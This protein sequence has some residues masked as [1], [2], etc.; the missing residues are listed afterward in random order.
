M[1]NVNPVECYAIVEA[2]RN[3][4]CQMRA[5]EI[6]SD[7]LSRMHA[8]LEAFKLHPSKTALVVDAL[9]KNGRVSDMLAFE[10]LIQKSAETIADHE[11]W[12]K[13]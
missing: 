4:F 11:W 5:G 9:C 12:S 7:P 13:Q 2:A 1:M 8:L 3:Q 6:A 10:D